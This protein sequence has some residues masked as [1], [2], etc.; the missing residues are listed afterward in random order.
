MGR[1]AWDQGAPSLKGSL[2][3]LFGRIAGFVR[4]YLLPAF[5]A[6]VGADGDE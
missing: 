6:K 5:G 1:Y 4:G 2:I 3:D